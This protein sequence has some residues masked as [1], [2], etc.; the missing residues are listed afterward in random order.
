MPQFTRADIF[1][2]CYC[3]LE[4]AHSCQG[5]EN[6]MLPSNR[7]RNDKMDRQQEMEYYSTKGDKRSD[8]PITS[9]RSC[10]GRIHA[11]KSDR[12][13]MTI[14]VPTTLSL[15]NMAAILSSYAANIT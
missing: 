9:G 8:F 6:P 7:A 14:Y 11:N 3:P 2:S 10:A 1:H 5:Q 13:N 12:M 15:T 4:T